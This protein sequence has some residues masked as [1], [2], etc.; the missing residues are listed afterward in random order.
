MTIPAPPIE[1]DEAEGRA[2]AIADSH[3]DPRIVPHEEVRAWLPR[4]AQGEWDAPR[5]MPR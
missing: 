3:A 1:D 5:P 4:L 2:L